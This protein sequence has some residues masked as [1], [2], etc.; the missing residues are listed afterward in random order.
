M[1]QVPVVLVVEDEPLLRMLA[2]DIVERAGFEAI[3]ASDADQAIGILETREDVRL[4]FTD[5]DMPGTMDGVKLAHYIRDRW[6]PILLVLGSSQAVLDETALPAGS[7]TF[8]K[9]YEEALIASTLRSMLGR[10][11][12][13][14]AVTRVLH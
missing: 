10:T 6:P 14:P 7:T 8:T 2:C 5:I 4:V 12:E 3:E 13:V 9:P 1:G 11:A